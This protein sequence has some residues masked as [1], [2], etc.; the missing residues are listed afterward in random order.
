MSFYLKSGELSQYGLRCGYVEA[1]TRVD[2]TRVQLYQEHSTY[3]VRA[4]SPDGHR[5][6]ETFYHDEL[7]KARKLYRAWKRQS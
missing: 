1:T 3:H 2:G 6:W 5:A 4:F 7:L